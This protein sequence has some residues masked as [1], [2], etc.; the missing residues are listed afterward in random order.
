MPPLDK[1][2]EIG[3]TSVPKW[4][5][6]KSA[7]RGPTWIQ[8]RM[9]EERHE[10]CDQTTSALNQSAVHK[11]FRSAEQESSHTIFKR[12]PEHS[13]VSEE[14][15][16]HSMSSPGR[17]ATRRISDLIDLESSVPL[18]SPR[19]STGP[20][21]ISD[22]GPDAWTD[23]PYIPSSLQANSPTPVLLQRSPAPSPSPIVSRPIPPNLPPNDQHTGRFLRR[24]SEISQSSSNSE[25]S[26]LTPKS[27]IAPQ[28][29]KKSPPKPSKKS[30]LAK[31][32]HAMKAKDT[33]TEQSK[34]TH[35]KQDYNAPA[36]IELEKEIT[37]LVR[38]QH[39][40]EKKR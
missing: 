11:N 38:D 5:K 37:K 33:N 10:E 13:T 26:N 19:S 31:S 7:L 35:T 40:R 4:W 28:S 39:R 30:G 6:E 8:R 9:Q 15:N 32:K 24:H 29:A 12:E 18:P 21:T 17:C 20:A 3:F 22:A 36:P 34:P 23:T 16:N 14:M 1:L 25:M 27:K 2:R